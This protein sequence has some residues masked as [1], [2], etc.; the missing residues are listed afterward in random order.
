[1]ECFVLF[2][3]FCVFGRGM[4]WFVVVVVAVVA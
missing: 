4:F 3:C 1:M 2:L